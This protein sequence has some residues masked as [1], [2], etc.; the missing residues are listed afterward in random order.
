MLKARVTEASARYSRLAERA[1]APPSA[2]IGPFAL[3]IGAA[4]VLL[5]ARHR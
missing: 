5:A 2:P 1:A 4:A 3:L